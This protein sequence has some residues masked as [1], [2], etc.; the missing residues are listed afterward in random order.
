MRCGAASRLGRLV[1]AR[2]ARPVIDRVACA[3]VNQ[4]KQAVDQ[5]PSALAFL[6]MLVSVGFGLLCY[7]FF[8][9]QGLVGGPLMYAYLASLSGDLRDLLGAGRRR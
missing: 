3:S 7:S 8:G 4:F 2:Q 9:W 6:T 5:M 1:P